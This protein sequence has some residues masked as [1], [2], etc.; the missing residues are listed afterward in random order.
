MAASEKLKFEA[1]VLEL[2]SKTADGSFRDAVKILE[3]ILT[4][5][6]KLNNSTVSEFIFSRKSFD[7]SLFLTLLAK[8]DIKSLL[9][10]VERSVSNG[11]EIKTMIIILLERLRAGLMSKIGINSDDLKLFSKQELIQLIELVRRNYFSLKVLQVK[12]RLS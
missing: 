7:A 4:A 8:R 1:G 12:T 6:I 5:D 2:I 10:E 9:G 3:Q 11:V